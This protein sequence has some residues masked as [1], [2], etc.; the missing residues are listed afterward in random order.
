MF[1]WFKKNKKKNE[2]KKKKNYKEFYNG[3]I[4]IE[5]WVGDLVIPK[6]SIIS[7]DEE[8]IVFK[9]NISYSDIEEWYAIETKDDCITYE[10]NLIVT[11]RYDT[12]TNDGFVREYWKVDYNTVEKSEVSRQ[13]PIEVFTT[14]FKS[15]YKLIETEDEFND[16]LASTLDCNTWCRRK[17][18]N[19]MKEVGLGDGFIN[20]FADLIGNDL[21][22]YHAMIDL[23]GEVSDKDTLMYLYTYKFGKR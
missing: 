16:Y 20:E 11:C 4:L 1:N 22:K 17:L 3:D 2:E 5:K 23:A 10:E 14:H 18:Y 12:Y 19:K 21:D 7:H 6:S 9:K 8:T 13:T 15:E